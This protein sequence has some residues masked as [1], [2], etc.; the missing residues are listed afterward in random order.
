[1]QDGSII[2]QDIHGEKIHLFP[3]WPMDWDVDF[4]L[5]APQKTIVSGKL[6]DGELKDLK[7][8][9][10]GRKDDIILHLKK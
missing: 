5:H 7:V 1:M 10:E 6:V 3:A 9:P 8:I 4:K 2:I